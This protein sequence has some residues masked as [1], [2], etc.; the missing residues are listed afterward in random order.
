M[1]VGRVTQADEGEEMRRKS[2]VVRPGST[3]VDRKALVKQRWINAINRVRDQ[4]N[5]VSSLSH[6]TIRY[7]RRMF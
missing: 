6:L 5:E 1:L 2:D 4:I 3:D 7:D